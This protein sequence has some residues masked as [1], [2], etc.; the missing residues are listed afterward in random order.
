MTARHSKLLEHARAIWQAG[1]DAV[2]PG[3]LMKAALAVRGHALCAGTLRLP[4]DEIGSIIVVG[5]GKAGAAMSRAAEEILGDRVM[6]EKN[7]RGC[8]NVLDRCVV[9]LR[10][11][12]LHGSRAAPDNKPT[13]AGIAGSRRIRELLEATGPNDLALCLVSGGGSALLPAPVAGVSLADKQAVTSLLHACGA[14]IGELNCV[15]KHLS[16]LKGGGFVRVFRGRAIVSLIISDVVGDPLD[17]IASGP[18]AA[19]SSTFHD[20]LATLEKYGLLDRAPKS[21]RDH[22]ELGRAG[23]RPETLKRLPKH[24]TNCIIGNNATA[25]AAAERAARR[26]G[27]RALNLSSFIEGD[28]REVGTVLA[29]IARGVRERHEPLSPP[30]CILSGGETTVALGPEHGLGGR[31]QELVLAAV[32]HLGRAGLR[33]IAF[34]SGG[35]DGE[36]GPT[37][38]AGA[39]AD[40]LLARRAERRGLDAAQFLA[41]HDSYHFFEPLGGLIRT[42]LTDTNVMDLRVIVVGAPKP[43]R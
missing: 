14:T 3:R 21:V 6:A 1:V 2:A 12:R 42:G 28:S 17:V 10:R 24:V 34:L 43:P 9:P 36:D 16:E 8:V 18:T 13:A 29:G 41:R 27:Y 25:L 38:A 22:L 40:E 33:D 37:D 30:A 5:T 35:T 19:D 32:H 15:R 26:L 20:A 11:I 23:D 4:L 7:L 31:N 39:V